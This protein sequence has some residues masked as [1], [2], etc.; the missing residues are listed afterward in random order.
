MHG[1]QSPA[2][3][4]AGNPVVPARI[5]VRDYVGMKDSAAAAKD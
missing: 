5:L 1:F 3:A 2:P 4:V